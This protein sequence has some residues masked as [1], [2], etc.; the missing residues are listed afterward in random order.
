MLKFQDNHT[1]IIAT[2]EAF[3]V[4]VYVLI[5]DLYTQ[6]APDS[7][8]KRRNILKAK[9]SDSEIITIGICG[10]LVGID[11]ENAWFS[12]VKK[13]YRNLFPK[14][15]SRTRLLCLMALKRSNCKT[16]WPRPVRQLIFRPRRRVETVFSQPSEQLNAERVRAKSFP[17]LC[18]RLVNKVLTYNLCL[19]LNFMLDEN[20]EMGKIKQLIF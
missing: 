7:V 16:D 13:N 18:T 10:E 14:F 2:F 12:F 1:T 15:C 3:I 20:Y 8:C 17:G 19:A 5:E 6:N 11:S 4:T 9:L